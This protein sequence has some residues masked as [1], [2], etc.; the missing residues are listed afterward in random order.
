MIPIKR[1][2]AENKQPRLNLSPQRLFIKHDI[3]NYKLS[4]MAISI[5]AV[6]A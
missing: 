2:A 4:G 1:Q 6:P 3:N 5:Q